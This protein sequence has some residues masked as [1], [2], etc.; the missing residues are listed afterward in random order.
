MM[1][2]FEVCTTGFKISNHAYQSQCSVSANKMFVKIVFN[3]K[4]GVCKNSN[5][6][7]IRF[8]IEVGQ[9]TSIHKA[10]HSLILSRT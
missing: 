5:Q 10:R 1:G 6:Q 9:K 8:D 3:K 7:K 2:N 4:T